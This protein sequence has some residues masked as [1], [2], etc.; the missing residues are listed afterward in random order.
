MARFTQS[1]T[2]PVVNHRIE[3]AAL[4]RDGHSIPIELSV[5][6]TDM[7][8]YF[9]ATAFLRDISARKRTE[10][11]IAEG[12]KRLRLV[13]DNMPALISHVNLDYRYT[14]VNAHYCGWFSRP[15]SDFVGK[16]VSE[17]FGP[18]VFEGVKTR[19]DQ[20][21]AGEDV[22]FELVNPIPGAPKYML[23]HYMQSA[24]RQETWLDSTAW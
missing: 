4:H 11:V 18:A 9:T 15:E 10:R 14:L 5:A 21:F 19:M 20:A 1:G 12:E 22:V 6:A 2:G 17:V 7:G 13:T 23:V 24:M 8:G 3:L 16:T